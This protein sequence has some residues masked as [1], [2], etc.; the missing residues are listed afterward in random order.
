MKFWVTPLS[1]LCSSIFNDL[2]AP[3]TG[4]WHRMVM[5]RTQAGSGE[6]VSDVLILAPAIA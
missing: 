2:P 1:G 3:L 6:Q 5:R 4:K